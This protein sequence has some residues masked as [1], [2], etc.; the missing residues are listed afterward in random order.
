M[1]GR[2]PSFLTSGSVW[3][4]RVIVVGR[5]EL[6]QFFR[7]PV[8]L[9]F[10]IYAFTFA[11]YDAATAISRELRNAS[12]AILDNDRSAS[13]RDL[14]SRFRPPYFRHESYLQ[15]EAQGIRYLDTG[16]AMLVLDVPRQF[17]KDLRDGR[18]T[19]VQVQIDGSNA[20]LAF[21]GAS[22]AAEIVGRYSQEVAIA[23]AGVSPEL[24]D[25][26][27]LVENQ[28]RVWFNPNRQETLFHALQ[29]LAQHILLF[30]LM[31]PAAALAR[32]K[33][34]GTAE[35]LLV[36]P[37]SPFQ[38]M[39][40]KIVPM[41]AVILLATALSLFAVI[42]GV[43]GGR[44]SGSLVLFF[45]VTGLF[46][47]CACGLG[48]LIATVTRTIAQVGIVSI[49]LLPIMMLLSGSDT[50]P[51]VMPKPLLPL[52]YA[53]P[54]HHYLNAAYGILLKG[55]G[56]DVL[57]DSIL[58]MALLGLGIFAFSLARFKRQFR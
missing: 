42:E 48:I 56:L 3:C 49:M 31:L 14:L 32:E 29:E 45:A 34:R 1:N 51:E 9:I 43:L 26:L 41:T 5:K 58:Y 47:F 50:P 30:S 40:G 57:W 11:V 8:L 13:S 46:S 24:V 33:E 39:L 15:S 21:L 25:S 28:Y 38:I 55:A 44:L 53:S 35:Q 20:T 6:L 27:P 22:Y 10:M 37:L 19:S 36:S 2:R 7:N 23:R 4:W 54:M 52:M 17:D 18:P 16:R 12:L